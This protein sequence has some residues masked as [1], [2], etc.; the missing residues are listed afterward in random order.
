[1]IQVADVYEQEGAF[2]RLD[3]GTKALIYKDAPFKKTR[4][5]EKKRAAIA[6][7]L[8]EC[9]V[10]KVYRRGRYIYKLYLNGIEHRIV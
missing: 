10:D 9:D 4:L 1:M 7:A 5:S 3:D 6:A 2:F 8:K